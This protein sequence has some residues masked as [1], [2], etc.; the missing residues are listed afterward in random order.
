MNYVEGVIQYIY[1]TGSKIDRLGSNLLDKEGI[2]LG[3]DSWFLYLKVFFFYGIF[4]LIPK[5]ALAEFALLKSDRVKSCS[6]ELALAKNI[7]YQCRVTTDASI[8]LEVWQERLSFHFGKLSQADFIFL[9]NTYGG[10]S[11]SPSSV[12]FDRHKS[13]RLIDFLPPLIQA[14]NEH[15]FIPE[16]TRFKQDTTDLTKYLYM[17]CWGLIYEVLRAAKNPQAQPTIF[18]GQASLMLAQLRHNSDKLLTLSEPSEFPLPGRLSKPGDIILITHKSSTGD[19]YLDHIVM[20]IDDGIYF[21][22]AGT[23]ADV[24][25]RLIDE[26]T[27][28]QIWQPGVFRYELRRMHQNVSLPHPQ[29]IF[30][31]D[32][33]A[34]REKFPTIPL[35]IDKNTTILWEVEEESRSTISWFYLI[36]LPPLSLDNTGKAKLAPKLYQPLLR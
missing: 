36:N 35:A 13:Y 3:K 4:L 2:K 26:A 17:N 24:P 7:P 9:Q 20:V 18:M 15:R 28:L 14:F 30:S 27:L 16:E 5:V 1:L 22:K 19:E 21:E 23:G 11:Q 12:V 29:A 32:S 34:V 33:P 25:I 31:L 6:V 10:W 8:P